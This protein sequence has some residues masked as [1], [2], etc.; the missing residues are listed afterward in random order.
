MPAEGTCPTCG[1]QIAGPAK[2]P[3]HFKVLLLSV[4]VYLG[5]RALQGIGWVVHHL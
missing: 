1:A 3:W 4:A 5:W 2:A